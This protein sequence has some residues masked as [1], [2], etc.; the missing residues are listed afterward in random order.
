MK[1]D[2]MIL[3]TDLKFSVPQPLHVLLYSRQLD[4]NEH[5]YEGMRESIKNDGLKNPLEVY[6]ISLVDVNKGYMVTVGNQRLK[7]LL[8]LG[9]KE[10]PCVWKK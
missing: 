3:T 7:A 9:I 1:Y 5:V 10:A 4:H 2:K 8:E 6:Q